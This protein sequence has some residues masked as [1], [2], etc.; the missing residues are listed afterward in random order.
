MFVSLVFD[1]VFVYLQG[2]P[3]LRHPSGDFEAQGWSSRRCDASFCFAELVESVQFV[4]GISWI[5]V[6]ITM[7]G[8]DRSQ[9]CV[10]IVYDSL[11]TPSLA[12][13]VN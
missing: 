7:N 1:G 3:C 4:S 8:S 11:F 12:E 13:R 10:D 9:V 2:P 5:H 6:F